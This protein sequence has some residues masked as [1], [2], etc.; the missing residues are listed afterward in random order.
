MHAI[1]H[2]HAAIYLL[3]FIANPTSYEIYKISIS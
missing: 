1:K 2:A 3:K